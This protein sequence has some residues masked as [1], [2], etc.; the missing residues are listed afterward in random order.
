[1]PETTIIGIILS[2]ILIN[3]FIFM[4]FLGL[5]PFL[6]VSKRTDTALGMGIAVTFVMV[7]ASAITWIIYIFFLLPNSSNILYIIFHAFNSSLRPEMFDLAYL[8]T[9]AFILVIAALVQ[10]V[11]MYL[12]KSI[13]ALY[14]SLGIYLPLIT[15]NCAILGIAEL[16][17][18]SY[19]YSFMQSIV[20]AVASGAGFTLALLLMSGL[21]EKME[22]AEIPK[23]LQGLP[24]AFITT[25]LMSLAFLGFS[26]LKF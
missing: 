10:F 26:G 17:T 15:T 23:P 14:S 4:R 16:N 19:H 6:G 11:E 5:C 21:R 24:I 3:N 13:P 20:F 2:G 1:M 7:L 12:Q 25:A 18:I 22:Y 8:E 9:I